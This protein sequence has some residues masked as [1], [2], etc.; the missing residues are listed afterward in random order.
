MKLRKENIKKSLSP[1]VFLDHYGEQMEHMKVGNVIYVTYFGART[2][3][4]RTG[5]GSFD[6][7][8]EMWR[9]GLNGK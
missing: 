4:Q 7:D 5:L 1:K 6:Y 9:A 2:R 8:I 3:I